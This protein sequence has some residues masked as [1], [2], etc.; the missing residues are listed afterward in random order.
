MSAFD[1]SSTSLTPSNGISTNGTVLH[2][3]LVDSVIQFDT[4]IFRS[5]VLALLPPILGA[6]S[7]EIES[8]FDEAFDENVSQFATEG[9]GVIYAVKRKDEVDGSISCPL[10]TQWNV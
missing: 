10:S 6:A 4:S 1:Q 9:G 3:S 7:E 5:Y 8:L 2:D